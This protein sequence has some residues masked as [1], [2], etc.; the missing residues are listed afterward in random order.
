M[1]IKI[2]KAFFENRSRCWE[3]ICTAP[4]LRKTAAGGRVF[5]QQLKARVLWRC[6]FVPG[7]EWGS[8]QLLWVCQYTSGCTRWR[9]LP[10]TGKPAVG[11]EF[12]G[13][14]AAGGEHI[15]SEMPKASPKDLYLKMVCNSLLNAKQP[16]PA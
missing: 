12:A 10:A 5:P 7:E 13:D 3:D 8:N 9:G 16:S 14:R 2:K 4:S 1:E 6:Q 15:S 11:M